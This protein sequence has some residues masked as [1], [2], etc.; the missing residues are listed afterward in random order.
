LGSFWSQ[1]E[2]TLYDFERTTLHNLYS[3]PGFAVGSNASNYSFSVH[4]DWVGNENA[5]FSFVGPPQYSANGDWSFDGYLA[6]NNPQGT[7]AYG[8]CMDQ[9]RQLT[10]GFVNFIGIKEIKLQFCVWH[11]IT[12]EQTKTPGLAITQTDSFTLTRMITIIIR[13]LRKPPVRSP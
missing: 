7:K 10:P 5:Y 1:L 12:S 3:S 9:V 11:S 13:S 2:N 8:M 6:V 4:G